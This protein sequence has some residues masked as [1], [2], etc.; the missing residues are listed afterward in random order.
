MT[1]G[2]DQPA[3]FYCP[4]CGGLMFQP[5]RSTLYWHATQDHPRCTIT[6]I[7]PKIVSS[8]ATLPAKSATDQPK[9][10]YS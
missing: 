10:T 3:P 8:S 2:Q 7:A 4:R 1:T 9:Q 5:D 6:N